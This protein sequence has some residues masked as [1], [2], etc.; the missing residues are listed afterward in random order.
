MRKFKK[1]SEEELFGIRKGIMLYSYKKFDKKELKRLYNW[2]IKMTNAEFKYYFSDEDYYKRVKNKD[3]FYEWLDTCS[4]NKT[5]ILCLTDGSKDI[6]Q[7]NKLYFALVD[8]AYIEYTASIIYLEFMCEI[9]WEDIYKFILEA[10]KIGLY[11]YICSNYIVGINDQLS[12]TSMS[13]GMKKLRK[14]KILTER[15][16]LWG[17]FDFLK[18]V[19]NGI[20]GP[21][22]IQVI[23]GELAKKLK[24]DNLKAD[25]NIKFR[26]TL[27]NN[28]LIIDL[29]DQ[30]YSVDSSEIEEQFKK[31]YSFLKPIILDIQ[32]PSMYWKDET[33]NEWR[34]RFD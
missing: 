18:K 14:S 28:N 9:S 32:R 17:N 22:F 8:E 1:I 30:D 4:H 19:K 2:F 20:D 16:S 10:N 5:N 15:Y 23:P 25:D 29:V 7:K 6:L 27:N 33:W 26:Y 12:P 21:D 34:T 13:Q 3:L 11:Y 31:M 24:F